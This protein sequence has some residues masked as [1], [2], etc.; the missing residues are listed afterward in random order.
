MTPVVVEARLWLGTPYVVRASCK[1]AGCDC[2]GLL[3]GVWRGLYGPEPWQVPFY[4]SDWAEVGDLD[5]QAALARHLRPKPLDHV[6][7]GDVVLFRIRHG[8]GAK[9]LG[10][11]AEADVSVVH[12][13]SGHGVVETP[14]TPSWRRRVLARFGW[15]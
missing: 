10:I 9:H 8:G 2:L 15:P 13:M 12:A 6:Q 4:P 5:L 14:W 7:A 11:E 3:R 1:G